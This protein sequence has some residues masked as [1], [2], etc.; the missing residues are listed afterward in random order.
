MVSESSSNNSVLVLII[1]KLIS[2]LFLNYQ[3]ANK[4][5]DIINNAGSKTWT[6]FFFKKCILSFS[7]VWH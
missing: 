4:T 6:F 3:H 1:L 7:I 2:K 5:L